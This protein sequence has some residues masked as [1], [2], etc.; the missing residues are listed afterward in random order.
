MAEEEEEEVVEVEEEEEEEADDDVADVTE[1]LSLPAE[2]ADEYEDEPST[3]PLEATTPT[4][5]SAGAG[6]GAAAA[7]DVTAAAAAALRGRDDDDVDVRFVFGDLSRDVGISWAAARGDVIMTSSDLR[8]WTRPLT[9][10][11]RRRSS[12][13]AD[14]DSDAAADDDD[15]EAALVVASE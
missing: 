4:I 13:D 5:G 12:F 10:A 2:P 3:S 1:Q 11:K 8:L 7:S 15:D 9:A 14:A 6:V